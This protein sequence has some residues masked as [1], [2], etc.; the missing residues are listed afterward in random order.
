MRL[1]SAGMRAGLSATVSAHASMSGSD[2]NDAAARAPRT[3]MCAHSAGV[4]GYGV[5]GQS[6]FFSASSSRVAST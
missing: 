4:S 2:P 5:G 1:H 3:F 6:R